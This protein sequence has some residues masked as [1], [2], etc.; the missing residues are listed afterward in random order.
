MQADMTTNDIKLF[1][2]RLSEAEK[3]RIKTLAAS[4]GLTL[5]EAVVQAFEA[6]AAQLQ[7]REH[8]P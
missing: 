5:R 1:A 6:W 7:S 8:T 2:V 3:R 4:Q